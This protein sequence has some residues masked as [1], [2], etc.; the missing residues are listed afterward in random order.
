MSEVLFLDEPDSWPHQVSQQIAELADTATG[1][2]DF[3]DDMD[4][5]QD[6]A[7]SVDRLLGSYSMQVYHASRLLPH[8]VDYIRRHGMQ[9]TT[10]R[11]IERRIDDAYRHGA[12]TEDEY[13]FVSA[14]HMHA[15][16]EHTRRG[17]RLDQICFMSSRQTLTDDPEAANPLLKH[18]G[19]EVIY[20]S[21]NLTSYQPLRKMGTPSI[22]VAQLPIRNFP[23][24][25]IMHISERL[26]A[27][28]L[29]IGGSDFSLFYEHPV[30]PA[31]IVDVWQPG[32]PE[33]D[34]YPGLVS[35]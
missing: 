30:T 20:Y 34:A 6:K 1:P 35:D 8:E 27:S 21:A 15:T 29:G 32:M 13:E 33:Y 22:I 2:S 4:C 31:Q 5:D 18:W 25:M 26:A 16:D 11:S 19:G 28:H 14:H 9:P 17:R 23:T 10:P 12:L 24:R 7:A 3:S